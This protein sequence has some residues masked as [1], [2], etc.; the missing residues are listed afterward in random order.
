M[1][2]I[3]YQYFKAGSVKKGLPRHDSPQWFEGFAYKGLHVQ[4]LPIDEA[5]Y[6][7]DEIK[8]LSQV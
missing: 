7:L 6:V 3:S 4:M 5:S 8:A 1:W 2:A